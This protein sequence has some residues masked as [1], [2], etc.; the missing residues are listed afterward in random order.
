VPL[1]T[2]RGRLARNF[3]QG[4]AIPAGYWHLERLWVIFGMI[5]TLLPLGAVAMMV[6]KP[7]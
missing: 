7:G 1:Q 6:F 4:G 5:A 2:K 3:A